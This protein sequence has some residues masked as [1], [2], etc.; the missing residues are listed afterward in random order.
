MFE[1]YIREPV[2]TPAIERRVSR[3][4]VM[5][6]LLGVSAAAILTKY[7]PTETRNGLVEIN[8]WILK[9]SDLA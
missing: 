9:R 5:Q 2:K 1:E 6:S 4:H 7:I 8:G 3:R